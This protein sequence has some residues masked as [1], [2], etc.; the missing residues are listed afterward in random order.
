MKTY[1][2]VPE[3]PLGIDECNRFVHSPMAHWLS[4]THSYLPKQTAANGV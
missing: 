2:G 3:T 1:F 4:V